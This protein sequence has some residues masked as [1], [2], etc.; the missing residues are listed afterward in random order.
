MFFFF[1]CMF[2]CHSY[3]HNKS[4]RKFIL[5]DVVVY[6]VEFCLSTCRWKVEHSRNFSFYCYLW[7]HTLY[8]WW[9]ASFNIRS[10]RAY[11]YH[12]YLFVQFRQENG[13]LGARTIPG[14]GWM[15]TELN[16]LNVIVII[17]GFIMDFGLVIASM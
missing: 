13:R 1:S 5:P 11:S 12:V 3:Q 15:V 7:Y 2:S 16:L 9:P 17:H 14:L 4:S 8:T 10:C 6:S